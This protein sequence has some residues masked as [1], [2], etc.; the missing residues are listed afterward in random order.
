MSYGTQK[1]RDG[2]PTEWLETR[3]DDLGFME[4]INEAEEKPSICVHADK[5]KH[6]CATIRMVRLRKRLNIGA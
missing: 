4:S 1:A 5:G 6:E 2:D 3:L